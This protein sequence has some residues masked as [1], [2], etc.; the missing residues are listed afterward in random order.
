MLSFCMFVIVA[1]HASVGWSK[2]MLV[3]DDDVDMRN[4]HIQNSTDNTF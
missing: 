3:D 1:C 2:S 4:Y